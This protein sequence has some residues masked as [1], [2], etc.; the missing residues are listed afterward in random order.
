M[1]IFSRESV[2]S[3]ALSFFGLESSLPLAFSFY[4][5]ADSACVG[6]ESL[7]KRCLK[8]YQ[9]DSRSVIFGKSFCLEANRVSRL[10]VIPL[11]GDESFWE[12]DYLAAFELDPLEPRVSYSLRSLSERRIVQT[13]PKEEL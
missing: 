6:S 3:F 5:K 8:R 2:I 10:H 13:Y 9:G 4:V 11:A 1:E 7:A 12:A